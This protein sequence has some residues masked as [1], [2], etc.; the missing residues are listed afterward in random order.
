M[1][2]AR[3]PVNYES[4]VKEIQD[5][6]G[7]AVG[8]TVDVGEASALSAALASAKQQLPEGS[9]LAAAVYNVNGGFAKKSFLE[10]TRAEL[11]DGLNS[12]V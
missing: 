4:I 3:N 2:L 7:K 10:L 5:A 12:S 1:L 11:D 9:K 8:V 6:G